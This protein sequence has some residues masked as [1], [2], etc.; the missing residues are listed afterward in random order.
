M[1]NELVA[2]REL[3]IPLT[4]LPHVLNGLRIAHV[5]D[6]HFH[7][8]DVVTQAAQSL[9][10][11]L[12]Y[13]L[14]AVTGDLGNFRWFWRKPADLA[15]RFFGP[16]A[17]H[18]TILAVLGNHD[19]PRLA[20]A[21]LPLRF[22]KNESIR[23]DFFGAKLTLAGVDQSRRRAEDLDAVLGCEFSQG[24]TILLAHY[25]ST[26]F[27]L[28]RGSMQLILSGHTHGGQIRLPGLGCLWT[29]DRIPRRMSHGLHQ[30]RGMAIH[31]SPGIGVS[32]P[33]R[34]RWNCP[35][36]VTVLSLGGREPTCDEA[37]KLDSAKKVERVS[38]SFV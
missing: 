17:E 20:D 3:S 4:G 27:R 29:N 16:L 22:L 30:V 6:F 32:L 28:P 34:I 37:S 7:R 21:H 2:L 10:L 8:W 35:P 14:L 24:P 5:S 12:D 36:E 13:D 33:L 38:E 11:K 25:P 26:V 23:L 18:G 19:N 31:V 9:L 1:G 15:R